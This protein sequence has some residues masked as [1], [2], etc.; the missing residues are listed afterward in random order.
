MAFIITKRFTLL[1]GLAVLGSLAALHPCRLCAQV[2]WPFAP[3]TTPDAQ[4]N[5]LNGVRAQLNWLLNA[6]RTAPNYR[7]GGAEKVWQEFQALRG[8]YNAFTSTLTPLQWQHGAN[9][10]AE[11]A[12]GLD[13]LQESFGNY[14]ADLAAGRFP[15]AALRNLCHVLERGARVWGQ[16]CSR[17]SA[18]L[19]VG[20][21]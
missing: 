2:P 8:A 6:T 9:E 10:L 17:V 1:A 3:H 13:I 15:A 19:R 11:L 16:E 18:R 21:F 14:E 7:A 4:R 20:W 12:A 5:A